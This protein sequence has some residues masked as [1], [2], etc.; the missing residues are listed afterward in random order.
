MQYYTHSSDL[1]K[2]ENCDACKTMLK[3]PMKNLTEID[4]KKSTKN[5]SGQDVIKQ[6]SFDYYSVVG[7]R[8]CIS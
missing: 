1:E 6:V 5:K 8:R 7:R 2:G 4:K 3:V